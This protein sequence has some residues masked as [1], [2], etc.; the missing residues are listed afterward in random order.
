M[1]MSARQTEWRSNK[2]CLVEVNEP[3][4]GDSSAQIAS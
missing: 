2:S 4:Q 3:R 1:V